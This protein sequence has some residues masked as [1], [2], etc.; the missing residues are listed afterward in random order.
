MVA[1]AIKPV[2]YRTSYVVDIGNSYSFENFETI[3]NS[4]PGHPGMARQRLR[5][6]FDTKGDV[7]GA[8]ECVHRVPWA[9]FAVEAYYGHMLASGIFSSRGGPAD[10]GVAR[11]AHHGPCACYKLP[12]MLATWEPE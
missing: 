4:V 5:W 11:H 12:L 3:F 10:L 1:L 7:C 2:H 6:L 8:R 9:F